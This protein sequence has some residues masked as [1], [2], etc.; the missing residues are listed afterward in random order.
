MALKRTSM[1]MASGGSKKLYILDTNVLVHD[2][3]A[4]YAFE[5]ALVGVPVVVLEEL[6]KFKH[7]GTDRGRNSRQS[8]RILDG[9]RAH[10]SLHDGVPLPKGGKVM[11]LFMPLDH[12][13]ILL[14]DKNEDNNILNIASAFQT[15][16]YAVVFFFK[17]L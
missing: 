10:G 11:V 5:G 15:A 1:I 6:D 13:K 3:K 16:G 9:L 2:P 8:I 12:K 4:L 7:E 14:V 17:Y